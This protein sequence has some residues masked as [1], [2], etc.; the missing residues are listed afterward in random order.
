MR[1]LSAHFFSHA[2]SALC[3]VIWE[4]QGES[5][6]WLLFPS[7]LDTA[8]TFVGIIIWFFYFIFIVGWVIKKAFVC[9]KAR[10]EASSLFLL[11]CF[12]EVSIRLSFPSTFLSHSVG[13]HNSFM[14]SLGF[15]FGKLVVSPRENGISMPLYCLGIFKGQAFPFEHP[16]APFKQ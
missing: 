12:A 11:S 4:P 2:D 7:V 16:R 14:C 9:I 15:P 5:L 8:V 1:C 6:I 10:I 3:P 13:N